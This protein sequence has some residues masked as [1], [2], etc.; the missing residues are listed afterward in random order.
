MSFPVRE[1]CS[2]AP[3][4]GFSARRTN[5]TKQTLTVKTSTKGKAKAPPAVLARNLPASEVH[6]RRAAEK[7]NGKANGKAPPAAKAN[8]KAPPAKTAKAKAPG[9]PRTSKFAGKQII[10]LR[11]D[12]PRREGTCGWKSYNILLKNKGK[13]SYDAYKAAG[14]RNNDLQWDLD[15]NFVSVK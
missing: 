15:H 14:G 5:M 7:R 3:G 4:L 13:M 8:G 9:I 1:G 10:C 6:S 11:K 2:P 12:N